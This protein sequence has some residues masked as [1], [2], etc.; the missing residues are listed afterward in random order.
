MPP[1]EC[2]STSKQ[3]SCT[4]LIQILSA[5]DTSV[6]VKTQLFT[7]H[8]FLQRSTNLGTKDITL[9]NPLKPKSSLAWPDPFAQGVTD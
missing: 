3:S 4:V 2:S 8:D 5:F 6:A 9:I 1:S 7:S